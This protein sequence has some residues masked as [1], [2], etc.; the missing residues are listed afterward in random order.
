MSPAP[1]P[2][3]AGRLEGK[4]A[5][6][7]GGARGLGA[8]QAVL[9]AREGSAVVVGDILD[10][11]GRALVSQIEAGGGRATYVHLDVRDESLWQEAVAL[12][13]QRYG[14][15]DVLV[16]SAG[17]TQAPGSTEQ[18]TLEEWE[19]V[20]G[21]NLTGTFLGAKAAIPA[22]QR[23]G[24]GSI[25]NTSSVVG[26][27]ASRSVAYGASKGGVRLLSKSIAMQHAK[28]NIRCNSFHP[29][30]TITP[31]LD[32]YYPSADALAAKAASVPLGRM[33]TPEEMALA[34]LYLA[35]DESAFMTGAEFVIDGGMT[36]V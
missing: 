12:A 14:K 6:I 17:V 29:G 1:E 9:F 26:L 36:A 31:F 22:M 35:S 5:L 16:N 18:T 13:E 20:I 4:V 28:Q 10:D 33:A 19:R 7:S 11:L 24:G 34:V 15:L 32:A 30:P 23:A 3:R 21:V 25:V 27:V 8:S 2:R